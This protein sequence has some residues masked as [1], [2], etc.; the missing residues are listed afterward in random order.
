MDLDKAFEEL[1]TIKTKLN[2][3]PSGRASL[4]KPLNLG[5]KTNTNLNTVDGE[6]KGTKS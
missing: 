5:S 3:V 4:M 1:D 2:A 6:K